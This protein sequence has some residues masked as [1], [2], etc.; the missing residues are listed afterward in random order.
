MKKISEKFSQILEALSVFCFIILFLLVVLQM[1]G[2]YLGIKNIGWT[3]ELVSCFTTYMAF[4]GASYLAQ[5]KSH[6]CVDLL[7]TSLKGIAAKTLNVVVEVINVVC[8]GG[9]AYSGLLWVKNTVGKKTP[10]L[11]I[12]Y[13]IWYVAIFIF[14]VLFTIFSL[15]NLFAE[16]KKLSEKDTSLETVE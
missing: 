15:V 16:I 1:L 10:I 6:V 11:Q 3:D 14:G 4:L 13:N 12:Q 5:R 8:G 7:S 2:R 9:I